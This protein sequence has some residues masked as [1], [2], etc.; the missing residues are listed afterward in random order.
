MIRHYLLQVWLNNVILCIFEK[1]V[2]S[3]FRKYQV[4]IEY[5]VTSNETEAFLHPSYLLRNKEDIAN[6]DL[7]KLNFCQL[8]N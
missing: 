3:R 6:F 1:G 5:V 8:L 7:E 2:Y 4:T